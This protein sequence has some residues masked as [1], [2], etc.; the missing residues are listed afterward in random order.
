[1]GLIAVI[2][3]LALPAIIGAAPTG[4]AQAGTALRLIASPQ[5]IDVNETTTVTL[6]VEN[7]TDLAGV[8]FTLSFDPA[9][10]EAQDADPSNDGV[11][12]T[13]GGL[14]SPDF[15]VFNVADNA[16]G[17]VNVAFSQLAP[18]QPVSGSGVL[19]TIVFRGKQPGVASLDFQ[20]AMLSN[21]DGMAISASTSGVSIV[22]GS[23]STFTPTTTPTPTATLPSGP[24]PTT[25]PPT[26]TPTPTT[27]S[28]TATP[29]PAPSPTST[30]VPL[31]TATPQPG[32]FFYTV[33]LGDNLFRLALRFGTTIQAIAQAN[34]IVNPRRIYVGQVLWIPAGGGSQPTV[35]VVQ[36]GDTLY[37]I[38]RR[39]GTTYQVLAAVNGLSNPRLIYVGQRLTIPGSGHPGP[40]PQTVH[41]VRQGDTL[42]SIALRYGTTP[43]AIAAA[44]GL[45]HLNLIY[46]GQRLIIP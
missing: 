19:A 27:A 37:S 38:A 13:L 34:G 39:F 28:P 20:N 24:T 17:V 26:S 16:A 4:L 12:V 22:V 11:Q 3:L 1:M 10:L 7:V 8:E 25:A 32:G 18:N 30:P 43:W 14:L 9:L 42:W 44:N 33:R 36:R 2:I 41:I 15:V 29:G 40:P 45:R 6:Q 46:V 21:A 35:Y 5:Q 23:T 31:P